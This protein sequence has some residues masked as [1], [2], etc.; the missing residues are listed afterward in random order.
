MFLH[1]LSKKSTTICYSGA[2]MDSLLPDLFPPVLDGTLYLAEVLFKIIIFRE[3][4]GAF[5]RLFISGQYGD[6]EADDGS[7]NNT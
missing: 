4:P 6:A 3:Y 5:S 1:F 2:P 7:N